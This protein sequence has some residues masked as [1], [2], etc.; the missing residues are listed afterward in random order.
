MFIANDKNAFIKQFNTQGTAALEL[1]EDEFPRFDTKT[2]LEM[3][4]KFPDRASSEYAAKLAEK[5]LNKH[6]RP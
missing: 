6:F 5:T 2:S 3:I 1:S 4:E